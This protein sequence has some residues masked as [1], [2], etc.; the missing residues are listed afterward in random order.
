MTSVGLSWLSS[1][2]RRRDVRWQ[3]T[4]GRERWLDHGAGYQFAAALTSTF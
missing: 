3:F 1:A 2:E 4:L